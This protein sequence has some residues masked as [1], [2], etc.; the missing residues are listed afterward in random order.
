MKVLKSALGLVIV[1][2]VL[3]G[4][5][6]TAADASAQPKNFF[7]R[8]CPECGTMITDSRTRCL[9][10]GCIKHGTPAGRAC[11]QCAQERR[12]HRA[13]MERRRQEA[14]RQRQEA[15]REL[16][17]QR[18]E[19]QRE[20]E[21]R[22]QESDREW[23][24]IMREWKQWERESALR[25]QES[26]RERDAR[27][28]AQEQSN[29]EL[30]RQFSRG[31]EATGRDARNIFSGS[32]PYRGYLSGTGV[33]PLEV[34]DRNSDL[35]IRPMNPTRWSNRISGLGDDIDSLLT[36]PSLPRTTHST[37][38]SSGNHIRHAP[39]HTARPRFD[40]QAQAAREAE[41]RRIAELAERRRLQ[42]EEEVAH[43]RKLVNLLPG[44]GSADSR[45]LLSSPRTGSELVISRHLRPLRTLISLGQSGH[46]GSA[47]PSEALSRYITRFDQ[48]SSTETESSVTKLSR[49]DQPSETPSRTT[50]DA[51][52]S[53]DESGSVKRNLS[54]FDRE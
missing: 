22:R 26:D 53:S 52:Q 12:E 49:F 6:L 5:H 20:F 13:Q 3:T 1:I 19:A 47:Q 34:A 14:E 24:R 2:S 4:M 48:P 50:S 35:F 23:E 15:Q 38:P 51:Q 37:W 43:T 21:R 31:L 30:N 44:V 7:E 33:N 8:Q 36:Q 45:S 41:Q 27:R 54:R 39:L 17:R 29:R 16:E 9:C 28:I 11:A 18:Q 32:N 40:Q 42:R 25:Q 10:P 46:D